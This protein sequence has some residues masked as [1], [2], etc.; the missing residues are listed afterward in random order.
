M[1]GLSSGAAMA[2]VL[3]VVQSEYFAAD[4]LGRGVG[5][6][7]NAVGGRPVVPVSRHLP[8]VEQTVAAIR[9]QQTTTEE[10][11]PV[12][13]MAIHSL[14]DCTVNI[15]AARRMR[16]SWLQLYGLSPT[17]SGQTDCS[18]EGVACE[19]QSFGTP[20]ARSWKPCSIRASAAMRR[21]RGLI[22]G[23]A[24]NAGPFANPQGP[25]ARALLWAFFQQHPFSPGQ[26]P[27]VAI[28]SAVAKGTTVRVEG[29]AADADGSVV[30]VRVRLDGASP[31]PK[32]WP[33]GTTKW[34]ATFNGVA[35]NTLYTPVATAVDNDGLRRP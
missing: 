23:W 27:T 32:S 26:A 13:A 28:A 10:R 9:A 17:P 4:R 20:S 29:S 2:V 25:S 15:E 7:R 35:N 12:P 22:T 3:G 30:Q 24:T 1:T 5:L 21:G 11:R 19:R 18:A 33:Q 8:T 34:S 6:W 31:Q 16:D 14:N